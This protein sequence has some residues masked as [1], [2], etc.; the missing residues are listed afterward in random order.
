MVN[1][2][3]DGKELSVEK[4]S[5]VL[6][7]ADSIGV[8]IP[9]ACYHKS[10]SPY[11]ACRICLV[12]V[13]LRGRTKVEAACVY[14]A[15]DGLIVHTETERVKRDR[16]IMAELLLARCPEYDA[17]NK[18]A[19]DLGVTEVRFP[20]KDKDC[21]LCG[22]CIRVCAERMGVNAIDFRNRGGEKLVSTPYDRKSETCITCG[23]CKVVCPIDTKRLDG[24]S[25]HDHR[26]IPAEFEE[27]L[28]GRPSV[29]VPFPQAVPKVATID[30]TTCAYFLRDVCKSCENFCQADAIDYEQEDEIVELETGAVILAPGYELFDAAEKKEL[31]Y[32]RY[33]NVLSSLQFERILSASGPYFGKVLRPSDGNAPKN[34]AFI[35]C[36]GSRDTEHNYCSSVCCMYA[37]KEAMIAMDHEPGLECSIFY[38]D[39]RAFGK[40]FDEY[41]QRAQDQG[42]RYVRCRPSAIRQDPATQDVIIGYTAEDGSQKEE[43]FNMAVLSCGLNPPEEAKELAEK[44]GIELNEHGFCRTS[45]I[46]PVET[47]REGIYTCGPFDEPKDIP[48]TVMQASAASAKAQSLLATEKWTRTEEK[49]YPPER[50][51]TGEEPRIGVFV[52][53]CG[54]NIGGVIDSKSVAEYASA[55]RDVV[56]ATDNLYTC[57]QD[58]IESI[59]EAVT[60]QNLNR[61]VVAACTPRTHE[62][63]FRDSIREAGLNPYL[64]EFANIRDQ[65]T[66]VHTHHPEEAYAKAKDLVRMAV[67]KARLLE[68]L[69]GIELEVTKSALVIGGGIGGMTSALELATQG[70]ETHLVERS[71]E[72]GGMM[73]RLHYLIDGEDPSDKLAQAIAQVEDHPLIKVHTNCEVESVGGSLGNFETLLTSNLEDGKSEAVKHGVIVVATG[74][75]EYQ[76]TEYLYGD[77]E[78][79]MTQ[80]ELE[81]KLGTG[82]IDAETVVMIQCVGSRED[83]RPYCSRICCTHAIKNALKIKERSPDANVYILYRDIRTYG[84]RESYY[85][86]ARDKGIIFLRYDKDRKP[87]VSKGAERLGV[88]VH[89]QML[90]IDVELPADLVILSTASIPPAD[91]DELGKKL[92]VPLTKDNFFLEAHMKLRPVDFASDGMFLA[93]TAHAPKT[94][95]ESII[96]ALG[97]AGRAS[98][99]LSKDTIILEAAISEVIDANC[100][101][102]AYCIDPCPYDAFTLIEYMHKGAVKKTVQ[103]DPSACKG[104]G[105]CQATCPKEGIRINHFRLDQL[106]AMVEALLMEG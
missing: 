40:G 6:E 33:P 15:Q 11:G 78:R 77:D 79:V 101:G 64:F 10:L 5:T 23:A 8:K 4:G 71:G 91:S 32:D 99:I 39:L 53:H 38:I 90:D 96:Q 83:D 66:W 72:L 57:S 35:Q 94:V 49:E 62:P 55:L 65:N 102:C 67:A 26:P 27:G 2:T 9:T 30:P 61:V 87:E 48:E 85:S 75:E 28:V 58:S 12:E 46:A 56:Y 84:F 18:L 51:V 22:K 34:I 74:A 50:D 54:K 100:D 42:V 31:G 44:F 3:I 73:T 106:S 82:D 104:C 37:T 25:A 70:F 41:Y 36:V 14:P 19:A 59:T 92:K 29:Y 47:S 88:I 105:V 60:E 68:P 81:E 45:R 24:I 98:T 17:M 43:T 7:A 93:G 16:A 80:L 97:A 95:D 103:R 63:L 76:P 21:L 1:I 13:E 86:L 20:K 69:Y 89:D 52:C